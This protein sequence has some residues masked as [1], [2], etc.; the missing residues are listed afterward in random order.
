MNSLVKNIR[1]F[2]VKQPVKLTC[3]IRHANYL[4]FKQMRGFK[5]AIIDP[6]DAWKNLVPNER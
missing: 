3:R 6:S 1:N 4:N 2:E 5:E